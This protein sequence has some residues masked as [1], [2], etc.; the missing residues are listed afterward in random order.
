MKYIRITETDQKWLKGFTSFLLQL[1]GAPVAGDATLWEVHEDFETENYHG[2][3]ASDGEKPKTFAE[4]Y[5][6][7]VAW[8]Q[9]Y[10]GTFEFYLS[11][12]GQLTARGTLSEK[13]L[14]AVRRAITRDQERASAPK[15]PR[16]YTIEPGTVIMVSRW[17]AEEIS[18]KAGLTNTFGKVTPH[19]AFE[20]VEVLGETDRA[21]R[22][23]LKFSAQR[24]THCCRCGIELTNPESVTMGIGPIC[25]EKAGVGGTGAPLEVL[26]ERLQAVAQ[27][28]TWIPKAAVKKRFA[29][30]KK[31]A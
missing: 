23:K 8:L 11:L 14:E 13:Q 9:A 28:E 1:G 10:R 7:E 30:E 15:V 29:L 3:E 18:R 27:V 12:K 25:A 24:T 20:V 17:S 19:F 22:L 6:A 26:R 2:V 16:S 4:K 21:Y 31:T 5:P